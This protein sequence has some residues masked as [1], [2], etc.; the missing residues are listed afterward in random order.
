[1]RDSPFRAIRELRRCGLSARAPHP[2]VRRR[3]CLIG[4]TRVGF[5]SSLAHAVL[6]GRHVKKLWA[7]RRRLDLKEPMDAT[8]TTYLCEHGCPGKGRL[9][10]PGSSHGRGIVALRPL[11]LAPTGFGS[12]GRHRATNT[13]DVFWV[14]RLVAVGTF[15]TRAVPIGNERAADL[16]NVV[17]TAASAGVPNGSASVV[18]R[19]Q[20]GVG[21]AGR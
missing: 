18:A 6:A 20:R 4:Y 2:V 5:R 1:M 14:G 10:C 12:P 17:G 21:S 7:D 13:R 16:R 8:R 3:R 19:R 11:L 9:A 15:V